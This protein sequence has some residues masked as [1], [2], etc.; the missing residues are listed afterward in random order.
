ML[1]G[2]IKMGGGGEVMMAPFMVNFNQMRKDQKE[3][4]KCRNRNVINEGIINKKIFKDV[5]K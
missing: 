3:R 2:Q 4:K 1:I 5:K